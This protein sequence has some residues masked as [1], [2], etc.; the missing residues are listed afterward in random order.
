MAAK[1]CPR[2]YTYNLRLI[3]RQYS[4]TINEIAELFR[5]HPNAVR[6]WRG[7]GLPTID[8]R[9]PHYVHGSDLIAFLEARQRARKQ[10]CAADEMFCCRCQA[11]RR[12]APGQVSLEHLNA[13][14]VIV[15]G[16]CELCRTAMNRFASSQRL[17]ELEATFAISAAPERIRGTA[18]APAMCDLPTGG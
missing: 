1:R 11:P 6:R 4:Y 18:D 3:R 14:H 2:K 12:P 16:P 10:R 9:R 15:R 8:D 13:R 7:A 17:S 5:V